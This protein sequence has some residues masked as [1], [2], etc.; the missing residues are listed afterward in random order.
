MNRTLV[1]LLALLAAASLMGSP[2]AATAE[3]DAVWQLNDFDRA[4]RY[5]FQHHLRQ[6]FQFKSPRAHV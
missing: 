5:R 1:L 3:T 2:T 4:E 6:R